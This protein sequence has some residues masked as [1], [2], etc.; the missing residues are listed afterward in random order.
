MS[1]VPKLV[2]FDMDDVLCHHDLGKRAREL[3]MITGKSPADIRTAIWDSGFEDEAE[4][5]KYPDADEYLWQFSVRI[6]HPV[7]RSEW[8][9][10]QRKS[11][12]PQ[13][14]VLDLARQLGERAQLAIL[15]GN[16]PL[17]KDNLEDLFPDA[18]DIFPERFCPLELGAKKPD[19]VSFKKLLEKMSV[20]PGDAWYIDE[21]K[22]H[23]KSALLA[24][25]NAHHFR[26]FDALLDDARE[27]GFPVG[28]VAK[29]R[30]VA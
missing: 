23:V 22:P 16:T 1:S 11:L 20:A 8:I 25:L 14:D 13:R 12:A 6:G 10:A 24:G 7:T 15:T 4:D 17:L 21:K 9:E 27:M 26:T 28:L 2:I 29:Q 5:G 19:T 3:S 30:E 18:A